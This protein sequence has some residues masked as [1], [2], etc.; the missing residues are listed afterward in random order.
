MQ[1]PFIVF[2]FSQAN[3]SGRTD[4]DSEDNLGR[5]I[6]NSPLGGKA[7]VYTKAGKYIRWKRGS[8][9]SG[10]ITPWDPF[11]VPIE[12][13]VV[14]PDY[15]RAGAHQS[16]QES[17]ERMGGLDGCHTCRHCH[18]HQERKVVARSPPPHQ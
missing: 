2:A 6:A 18:C 4:G 8:K 12:E 5:G 15:S 14:V 11:T 9:I 10:A 17:M 1:P 16:F 13:R 3:G 7:I